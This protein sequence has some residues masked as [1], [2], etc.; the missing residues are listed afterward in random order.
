M[1]DKKYFPHTASRPNAYPR[2][3]LFGCLLNLLM[4]FAAFICSILVALWLLIMHSSLPLDGVV[5]LIEKNGS[6]SNIQING[7]S[8]S[9]SSGVCFDKM[10]WDGGEVI[11][12]RVQFSGILDLIRGKQLIFHDV[13]VGSAKMD[14]AAF[15][16][17]F[18]S[19]QAAPSIAAATP[20]SHGKGSSGPVD[21]MQINQLS[22]NRLEIR[23]SSTGFSTMIDKLEWT[24]FKVEHGKLVDF[25]KINLESDYLAFKNTTSPLEDFQN[26]LEA[27]I[28]PKMHE[29]VLKPIPI[30]LDF[31]HK[32]VSSS[33]ALNALDGAVAISGSEDGNVSIR[34][35]GAN[36]AEY[37]NHPLPQNLYLDAERTNINNG[38]AKIKINNGTF[39]LGVKNFMIPPQ[40][41]TSEDKDPKVLTL[42]AKCQ[43]GET[44]FRYELP[45]A[46]IKLEKE[47]LFPLPVLTS[48]PAL[49]KTEILALVFHGSSF[50]TLTPQEQDKLQKLVPSFKFTNP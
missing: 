48:T 31:N 9:L 5:A 43:D 8:G 47:A 21:R 6:Q 37:I 45:I 1:N 28:M 29:S 32:N 4:G 22:L 42:L 30:T 14:I 36:L 26:R 2:R 38:H 39:Q 3:N 49:P 41:F 20:V 17:L 50:T 33:I 19:K 23:D 35:K 40:E 46:E 25:G 24:G 10:T 16:H 12:A 7:V 11:D 34:A 27:S 13:H 15:N 18:Q 44:E